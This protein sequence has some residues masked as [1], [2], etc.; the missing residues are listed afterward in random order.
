MYPI[1][2]DRPFGPGLYMVPLSAGALLGDV[3]AMGITAVLYVRFGI[4]Y[5][6]VVPFPVDFGSFFVRVMIY[7]C[8]SI[9]CIPS[10]WGWR[11]DAYSTGKRVVLK[12]V[13]NNL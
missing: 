7:V 12:I 1:A 9:W 8:L 5:I 2:T 13:R 10:R 4:F 3:G 6:F 11:G